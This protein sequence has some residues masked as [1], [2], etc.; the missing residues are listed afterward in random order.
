MKSIVI[1]AGLPKTGTSAVQAW[2]HHNTEQLA[3]AGVFYPWHHLDKNGI[4]AGNAGSLMERSGP[5][6]V[7][8]PTQIE[9]TLDD[10]EASGCHTMLLSSEA[11]LPELPRLAEAM[12]GHARFVMYVRDPLAFLESDYNQRVKRIPQLHAFV[13]ESGAY[14]GWLGHEHLYNALAS[15]DVRAR[16]ELRPY[17]SDLFVGGSLLTDLLHA[18]GID[19]SQL[20]GLELKQ[21]NTSY[22]LHALEIKR[23]LNVLPL[24]NELNERLDLRLQSCTL[25]PTSYSLIPPA[26]Y[27]R[28]RAEADEE[29]HALSVKYDIDSLEPLRE[30]LRD[31]PSRPY[32][33]QDLSEDEVDAVV[34]HLAKVGKRLTRRINAAL[35]KHPDVELAYPSLR[36]S[37]ARAVEALDLAAQQ[38]KPRRRWWHALRNGRL[39]SRR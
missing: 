3:A 26:D 36:E 24:G 38:P 32:H 23:A 9:G 15:D 6:F 19:S 20:T 14:G 39:V 10:F 22:S 16:A 31:L 18:A 29:L 30:K 2:L 37:F 25:G 5:R 8:S 7:T 33:P 13:P 1:H 12:P 17:H 21:V 28:L 4:S 11:F 27:E 34:R 35:E